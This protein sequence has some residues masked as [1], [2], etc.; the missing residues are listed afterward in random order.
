MMAHVTLAPSF[1]E[2][3]RLADEWLAAHPE[4][5]EITRTKVAT[6]ENGPSLLDATRCTVTVHYERC[7]TD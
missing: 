6:G 7:P 5:R 3:N 1:E 4:F 2:A